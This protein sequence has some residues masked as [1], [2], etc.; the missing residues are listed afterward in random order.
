MLFSILT[1]FLASRNLMFILRGRIKASPSQ[2][3][4]SY[5][6]LVP[7]MDEASSSLSLVQVVDR[8]D[9][10][11]NVPNRCGDQSE[12]RE[13]YTAMSEEMNIYLDEAL[14]SSFGPPT[15][16]NPFFYTK[17]QLKVPDN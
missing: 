2:P 10:I 4:F 12:P 5:W 8:D 7:P 14:N 15:D 17:G 16:Y 13:M 1:K 3:C 9:I 6:T 11:L